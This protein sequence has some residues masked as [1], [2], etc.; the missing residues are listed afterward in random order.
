M[1]LPLVRCV[2]RGAVVTRSRYD[3]E[4]DALRFSIDLVDDQIVELLEGRF[5][6]LE[7]VA[8]LKAGQGV[9][10]HDPERER[11]ILARLERRVAHLGKHHREDLLKILT[12]V[13]EVGRGSVQRQVHEHEN[14]RRHDRPDGNL[15]RPA[16]RDP[17]G[18]ED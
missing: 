4:L 5:R 1:A 11:A 9:P 12:T 2:A 16:R 7:R 18:E 6:R 10:G 8:K 13:V 3:V 15:D 14:T 17:Q